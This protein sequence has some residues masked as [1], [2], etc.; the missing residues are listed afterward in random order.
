[1]THLRTKLI[2]ITLTLVGCLVLMLTLDPA[3]FFLPNQTAPLQDL[4]TVDDLQTQFNRD[5]GTP[6]LILLLSP[7]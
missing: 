5:A 6:R 3:G 2:L 4:H 7:T 1:M